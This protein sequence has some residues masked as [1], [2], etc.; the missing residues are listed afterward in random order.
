[1]DLRRQLAVVRAW[2]R[3]LVLGTMVAAGSAFVV[4]LQLPREYD[5]KATL[6]VGQSLSAVNTDYN[7]LLVSQRL[8]TTYASI[9][10]TRPILEAAI[11]AAGISETPDALARRVSAIADADST[12]LT[13]TVRDRDPV[14]AAATANAIADQ[15][16]AASPTIRGLQANVQASIDA[17]LDATLQQ[18]R[19]AEDRVQQ[20]SAAPSPGPQDAAT[21]DSLQ[22]RLVTLRSTYAALLTASSG[23]AANA[24]SIVEPAVVPANPV[25]PNPL[26][27][28]LLAGIFGLLVATGFVLLADYLDDSISGPAAVED[29]ARMSTL[30]AIGQMKGDR[31]G[32]ELY[33]LV[34]LLQP[35][36]AVAEAYRTL[37]SNIEFAAVDA[38]V[39]TLLVTS[40]A[41]GEGKTITAANLAIVFAQAGRRV[42]LVD[43]DLRKPGV[44]QVFGVPNDGLG[45]T[46]ALKS[47]E[48][49]PE[50][51]IHATEEERL[52]VVPTGA[53]PPNPAELLGSQRMR[54]IAERLRDACDL[55]IFD[56]PPL[57]AVADAA[58]LSSIADGTLMVIHARRSHR[59]SVRQ[60]RD[61]LARAGARVL[62]AVLN[63]LPDT[64]RSSYASYYGDYFP[65][66]GSPGA[67]AQGKPQSPAIRDIPAGLRS[68]LA[69][70]RTRVV[71]GDPVSPPWSSPPGTPRGGGTAAG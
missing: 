70:L 53:L 52:G 33:R 28:A 17:E 25:A 48:V 66:D 18:I 40:A 65:P 67:S 29:F 44:N 63:G 5:A 59:G 39:R 34:T 12:L 58:I 50:Q 60:G 16:T 26:L 3:L 7:Q 57:E 41:P 35:R 14:A 11:R 23:N 6:I 42:V 51:I 30:A 19:T 56:S 55:L 2:L 8:S 54:M 64:F 49:V 21:L 32:P 10:T 71:G 38:P 13:I 22:A 68:R 24:I 15:L 9:A 62:G 43:A 47:D 45:L 4:S 20:L 36:S 61:D 1:M 46:S 31:H 69:D 27:N 37:R